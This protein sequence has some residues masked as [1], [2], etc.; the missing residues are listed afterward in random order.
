MERVER[1]E[2]P[3][4]RVRRRAVAP[5]PELERDAAVGGAHAIAGNRHPAAVPA[6]EE[7]LAAHARREADAGAVEP[8][9]ERARAC[10][11]KVAV[12]REVEE[13]AG[14]IGFRRLRARRAPRN[15]G[16][17]REAHEKKSPGR[18]T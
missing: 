3:A 4:G 8:R 14:R 17:H 15:G 11:A 2:R 12:E 7:G 1:D 18:H 13:Q 5:R 9:L 16:D 10:V 6:E